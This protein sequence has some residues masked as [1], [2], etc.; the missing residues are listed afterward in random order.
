MS[1]VRLTLAALALTEIACAQ[2]PLFRSDAELAQRSLPAPAPTVPATLR[3]DAALRSSPHAS[4][5]VLHRLQ[6]G[7]EVVAAEEGARGFR[8]VRTRDGK[9]GFVE[10]RALRLGTAPADAPA[11]A[12]APATPGGSASTGTGAGGTDAR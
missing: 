5:P 11:A 10:E 4:A 3:A 9:S 7:T 8:R 2:K 12:Q 6:S 1:P